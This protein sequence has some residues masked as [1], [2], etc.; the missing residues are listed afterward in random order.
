M[1]KEIFVTLLAVA[2]VGSIAAR[3]LKVDVDMSH[4]LWWEAPEVPCVKFTLSDTLGNANTSPFTF[5][6]TSDR[7]E[8]KPLM[9]FQEKASITPGSTQKVTYMLKF[10]EPGFYKCFIEDE[11][12]LIKQFNIGYEPTL[13]SS[14]PDNKSDFGKFWETAL[15]D[16]A[17]IPGDFTMTEVTEKSGQKRKVYDVTMQSLEN[18]TV[19][20]RIYIPV[21]EG[22]YP[23]LIFYN[24][25][26]STPWDIDPD[27]RNDLIEFVTSVRGQMYSQPDNKYGDW[28]R[29]HLDDPN[30]YYYRGAYMDAVRAI[31]FVEQLPMVDTNRIFAEGGSQGGALTLAAAALNGGRLRAIMPYIPFMSDFPDYFKIVSWPANA[32]EEEAAK[33]GLTTDQIYQ[34]MSYFDIKN[35]ARRIDCPVLMG[36][37]LQDPVCPPHTNMASYVLIKSPKQLHIYPTCGHTVDYSDWNPRRDAFIASFN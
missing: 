32:V 20:G 30:T 35:L 26:G 27:G 24:G 34:N 6:V 22:K 31:D 14:L 11:G 33:L 7:D 19:K 13:V 29:Y 28:I 2:A 37:G 5:R 16:L 3:D 36:I 23:A 15:A 21:A 25:Y 10:A 18:E 9:D 8:S 17:A 1:K 12:N 4:N